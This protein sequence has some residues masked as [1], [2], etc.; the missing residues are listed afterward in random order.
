M[1]VTCTRHQKNNL[2]QY[3]QDVVAMSRQSRFAVV[4]AVFGEA[5]PISVPDVAAFD[6][7]LAKVCNGILSNVPDKVRQ[8]IDN[9]YTSIS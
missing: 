7:E 3:C 4:D 8:H 2:T 5:G 6:A 1:L 9:R